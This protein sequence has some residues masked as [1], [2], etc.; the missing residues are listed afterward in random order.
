M[1]FR[2]WSIAPGG[3]LFNMSDSP[4]FPL[5][6]GDFETGTRDLS[7]VE[8]TAYVRCLCHQWSKG[9]V[10]L[11]DERRMYRITGLLPDE[12]AEALPFLRDKF[13]NGLNERL[14]K[15][16]ANRESRSANGKKGGRPKTQTKPVVKPKQKL[17]G[18]LNESCEKPNPKASQSQSQSHTK[19]TPTAREGQVKRLLAVFNIDTPIE[20]IGPE[21][22]RIFADPATAGFLDDEAFDTIRR[23]APEWLAQ[24]W[25]KDI[26]PR[27]IAERLAEIYNFQPKAG[28]NGADRYA[29]G[30]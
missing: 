9:A 5:Y 10:P 19:H 17:N 12:M 1:A 20:R 29:N 16:R 3:F 30:F 24:D 14:A 21:A 26:S 11:D 22:T 28:T 13:P 4:W 27:F 25:I 23:K 8:M 6:V 2:S 15:E 7:P 18:N